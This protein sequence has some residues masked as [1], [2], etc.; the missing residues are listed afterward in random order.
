MLLA[1]CRAMVMANTMAI[2]HTA[3]QLHPSCCQRV[4]G[5]LYILLH[6]RLG[7][8][9][10]LGQLRLYV[11]NLLVGIFGRLLQLPLLGYQLQVTGEQVNNEILLLMICRFRGLAA[12]AAEKGYIDVL[13]AED[14][15]SKPLQTDT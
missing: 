6:Q 4:V 1:S 2:Q 8:L 3:Q 10:Y 13:R 11:A 9:L 14:G 15:S 5:I 12:L 7:G